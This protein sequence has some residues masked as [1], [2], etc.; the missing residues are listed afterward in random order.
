MAIII[1]NR[2][3][4]LCFRFERDAFEI[5]PEIVL[6]CMY[7]VSMSEEKVCPKC[8]TKSKT[9]AK[10]CRKCGY[11]LSQIPQ[12]NAHNQPKTRSI[13]VPISSAASASPLSIQ[14]NAES[15]FNKEVN[16]LLGYIIH[17]KNFY[18]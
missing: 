16:D 4:I 7:A 5:S 12:Q 8:F 11:K 17:S 6:G 14:D 2:V 13:A 18:T 9:T 10:F 3:V 1:P 15:V